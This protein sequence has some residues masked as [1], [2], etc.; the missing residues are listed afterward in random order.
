MATVNG[1]RKPGRAPRGDRRTIIAT[2]P[3]DHVAEYLRQAELRKLALSEYLCAELARDHDLEVPDY[4][5]DVL[6]QVGD[7]VVQLP[8]IQPTSAAGKRVTVRVPSDHH[9][10]YVRDASRQGRSL[11]DYIRGRLAARHRF[12]DAADVLF[13]EGDQLSA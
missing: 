12:T 4:I 5:R 10:I 13:E 8:D 9:A 6:P 1:V 3:V 11:A 2:L 7:M